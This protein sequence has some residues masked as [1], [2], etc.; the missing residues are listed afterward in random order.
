M[1][2]WTGVEGDASKGGEVKPPTNSSKDG[3]TV[4]L[5]GNAKSC[6]EIPIIFKVKKY[7]ALCFFF[8]LVIFQALKLKIMGLENQEK[9]CSWE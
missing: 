1:E 2:R 4:R 5:L 3:V 6:P 9:I 7:L 8:L